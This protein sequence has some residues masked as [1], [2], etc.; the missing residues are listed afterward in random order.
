VFIELANGDKQVFLGYYGDPKN[1]SRGQLRVDADLFLNGYWD[2]KKTYDI[3]EEGYNKAHEVIDGWGRNG[4]TWRPW[5]N[6]GDFAEAVATVAGI[7]FGDLPKAAGLNTPALWVKYLRAHG[8][9]MNPARAS[10]DFDGQWQCAETGERI[11]IGHSGNKY[12]TVF[13][14]IHWTLVRS[15]QELTDSHKL[16]SAEISGLF[17]VPGNIA[18]QFVGAPAVLVLTLSNANDIAYA[19]VAPRSIR[20]NPQTGKLGLTP[21]PPLSG[22]LVRLK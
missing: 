12:S 1:P 10:V 6:C 2:V 18:Q 19:T 4:Q 21:G 5:C 9:A 11:T 3:S 7:N 14:G 13:F 16:T 8:G 17:N 20:R 15:G 22:T